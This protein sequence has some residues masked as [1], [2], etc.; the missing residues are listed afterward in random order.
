VKTY[1][2]TLKKVKG[3]WYVSMTV[4][5]ELRGQLGGQLRRSTGTSD[6]NEANKR[7]PEIALQIQ[8]EISKAEKE[9]KLVRFLA[10]VSDIARKLDRYDE[11]DFKNADEIS[12][13]EIANELTKISNIK[14]RGIG[15]FNVKHLVENSKPRQQFFKR[16]DPSVQKKAIQR[17]R[18]LAASLAPQNCNFNAI[19]KEWSKHNKW[20]REKSKN[21]FQTHTNTF[22]EFSG[23]PELQ[24]ITATLLYDFAEKLS[25]DEQHSNATVKNYISSISAVLSHGIRKGYLNIN[26]AKDLDLRSYGKPKLVR[27]PFSSD[28]L[29]ALFKLDVSPEIRFLWSILITTGMR[30]DEAALL[31]IS[32]LKE[33]AGIWFFDLTETVVKNTGSARKVPVPDAIRENLKNYLKTRNQSRLFNFPINADGKAQ[34]AASKAS[35]RHIRKITEDRAFVTHSFRHSFKD[36]CRNAEIPRDLHDFITGHSGGDSASNYGQG[37]SLTAR[38]RAL[39]LVNHPW[40]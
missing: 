17:A 40:L 19:A 31:E 39:D 29:H 24:N 26:P 1:A 22:V 9:L 33:E 16:T 28:Q 5:E 7:L 4:P 34:N 12:L 35:M 30:L 11:F 21:A 27:K 10:E 23:N 25:V 8:T 13:N 2:P 37:H 14:R 36:L 6:K 20:Q 18:E 3:N 32:H 15:S 38:K